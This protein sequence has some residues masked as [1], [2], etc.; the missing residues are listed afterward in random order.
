M[1]TIQVKFEISEYNYLTDVSDNASDESV[2]AYFIGKMFNVAS[3]TKEKMIKCIG[4]AFVEFYFVCNGR[5]IYVM[6]NSDFYTLQGFQNIKDKGMVS[7]HYLNQL[8]PVYRLNGERYVK[9]VN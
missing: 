2:E 9:D 5:K 7:I 3:Y 6:E 8:R 1:K 4:V